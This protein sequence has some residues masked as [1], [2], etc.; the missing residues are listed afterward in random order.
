[1][2]NQATNMLYVTP[3]GD[4]LLETLEAL[5]M[6]QVELERRTG[7]N[8]K[9]INQIIKGKEPIT[10]NT[11]LALEKVLKVPAHFWMNLECRY[12]E[13]LAKAEQAES[14][15]LHAEWVRTFPYPELARL[16]F[17][18]AA[19]KIGEKA[20]NLLEF[21]GVSDPKGWEQ[22]YGTMDLELSF[23][24]STHVQ[25][26]RG[27]ISAWLRKGELQAEQCSPQ[28]FDETKFKEAIHQIRSLTCKSPDAFIPE[29]KKLCAEAGVL[30]ILVPELSGM[31][32]SGVMRWYRGR[33]MI[34]QCLRFK[35]NDQF[36]FTFFHEA[37]HVLQ[38]R[39]KDIFIEGKNA[40]HEDQAREDEA[41]RFSGNL[42]IPED[43]WKSFLEQFQNPK[44]SEIKA[45]ANQIDLHPGIVVGRLMREEI[46][47]YSHPARHLI[48]KYVWS[49]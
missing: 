41:N 25:Q 47:A 29:M 17:L 33:P 34:Q 43:D 5:G 23:R 21:F 15:K 37:K 19:T 7:I 27:A 30:Y 22:T 40:Q 26:K 42:L 13:H 9:T 35:G 36:W 38:K 8:K 2:S 39:K 28:D 24:Q 6:S 48:S 11:S 10:Q 18:P 49:V 1:M 32:I 44:S 14:M 45:F 31:G 12:R 20:T 4:T 16:S 46:L 3:P